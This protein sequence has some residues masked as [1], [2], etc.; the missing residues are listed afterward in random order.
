[1]ARHIPWQRHSGN[2]LHYSAMETR[3]SWLPWDEPTKQRLLPVCDLWRVQIYPVWNQEERHED[4][5][6]RC[7]KERKHFSAFPN[8]QNPAMASR[9]S[10]LACQ[11]IRLL[12]SGTYTLSR[13][14]DGMTITNAL[15]N[16][17]IGTPSIVSDGW[18]GSR[19]MPSISYT[20]LRV[21]LTPIRHR[22]ATIQ[23]CTL[24]TGGG[25]TR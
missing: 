18:C 22:N 2:S 20:P 10:W 8:L 6:W 3:H 1:M 23:K 14:C 21:A 15:S 4:V 25:R 12:G 5:L 16:T 7:A 17:G 11:I 9:T 24:R 19:A 13:I